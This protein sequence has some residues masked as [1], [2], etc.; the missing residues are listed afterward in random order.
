M[1]VDLWGSHIQGNPLQGG[2]EG[3]GEPPHQQMSN[4]CV[5]GS[6][7]YAVCSCLWL[8]HPTARCPLGEVWSHT[9]EYR[10]YGT[11]TYLVGVRRSDLAEHLLVAHASPLH[12][13]HRC[14]APSPPAPLLPPVSAS[15]RSLPRSAPSS[16]GRPMSTRGPWS[17]AAPP[18]A[19]P[20]ITSRSQQR[21]RALV[22]VRLVPM[23]A[24]QHRTLQTARA[25]G[26]SWVQQGAATSSTWVPVMFTTCPTHLPHAPAWGSARCRS[27]CQ[28]PWCGPHGT[29]S[30]CPWSRTWAAGRT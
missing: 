11:V 7:L 19:A 26:S 17:T 23:H 8:P 29:Q 14:S 2:G 28:C 13:H 15:A 18:A 24:W 21:T 16:F 6:V 27:Q 1:H 30:V 20:S 9:H 12:H 25:Y 4:P 10:A 3:G 22:A 5:E